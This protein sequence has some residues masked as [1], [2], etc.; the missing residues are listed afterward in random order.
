MKIASNTVAEE[1]THVNR[2]PNFLMSRV[3]VTVTGKC[4]VSPPFGCRKCPSSALNAAFD[5]RPTSA[6]TISTMLYFYAG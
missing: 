6:P 3:L 5:A 2:D 4:N 1:H